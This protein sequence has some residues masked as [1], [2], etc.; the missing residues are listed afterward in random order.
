MTFRGLGYLSILLLVSSVSSMT[1]LSIPYKI[2]NYICVCYNIYFDQLTLLRTT[3]SG[4]LYFRFYNTWL[5]VTVCNNKL[6]RVE[7]HK[8]LY[9]IKGMEAYKYFVLFKPKDIKYQ[10]D[11]VVLTLTRAYSRRSSE[12]PF[13]HSSV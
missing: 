3:H 2:Y 8:Y 7:T 6:L 11:K 10:S 9:D 12:V 5:T 13:R 1:N 4:S